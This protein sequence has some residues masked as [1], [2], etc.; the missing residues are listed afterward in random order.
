MK[1]NTKVQFQFKSSNEWTTATSVSR[2][3]KTTG[4]YNK[5][6]NRKLTDDRIHPIDFEQDVD[7][8]DI[9]LSNNS[10]NTEKNRVF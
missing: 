10:V 5:E 8:L 4:K 7:N 9:I 1:K 2:S 6:L 3:G